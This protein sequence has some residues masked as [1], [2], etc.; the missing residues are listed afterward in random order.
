MEQRKAAGQTGLRFVRG[1]GLVFNPFLVL[2][3]HR[4][5]LLQETINQVIIHCHNDQ[6]PLGALNYESDSE[7]KINLKLVR[8]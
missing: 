8:K 4:A 2:K 3:V 7:Q 1:V 5:H 6:L